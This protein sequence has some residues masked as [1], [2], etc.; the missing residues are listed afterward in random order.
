MAKVRDMD[1]T[2]TGL[3]FNPYF[4]YGLLLLI[5]FASCVY[6]TIYLF[7]SSE[8][9]VLKL[10]GCAIILFAGSYGLV[11]GTKYIKTAWKDWNDYRKE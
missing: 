5:V 8:P 1:K 11:Y 4:L 10:I 6:G 3:L 2:I 7:N 9:M